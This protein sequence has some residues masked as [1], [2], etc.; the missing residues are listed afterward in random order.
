[1]EQYWDFVILMAIKKTL[2]PLGKEKG[3]TFYIF[4]ELPNISVLS[5]DEWI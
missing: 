1:M 3:M 4:E 2:Y 5:E